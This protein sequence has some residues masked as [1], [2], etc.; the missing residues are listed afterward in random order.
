M[1]APMAA[2]APLP[3]TCFCARL[4]PPPRPVPSPGPSQPSAARPNY[5]ERV[6]THP[7]WKLYIKKRAGEAWGKRSGGTRGRESGE[8]QL[9][10]VA[11][12]GTARGAPRLGAA[13]AH[14]TFLF[15]ALSRV[16]RNFA[17]SVFLPLS[18]SSQEKI[19]GVHSF[20]TRPKKI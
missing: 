13:I 11:G 2:R 3:R 20:Y 8:E 17:P 19:L 10:V 7:G 12:E 5:A 1:A 6:A 16:S 15:W 18:H 9:R 4:P 14:A